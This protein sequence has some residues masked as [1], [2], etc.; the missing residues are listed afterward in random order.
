MSESFINLAWRLL[1]M[2]LIGAAGLLSV[3]WAYQGVLA[4]LSARWSA[5]VTLPAGIVMGAAVYLL[6]RYR[7]DLVCS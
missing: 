5:A 7:N 3:C 6:C 2:C 4:I 1:M